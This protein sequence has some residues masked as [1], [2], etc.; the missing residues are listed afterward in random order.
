MMFLNLADFTVG[1]KEKKA[2][3]ELK[4][5]DCAKTGQPYEDEL[6]IWDRLYADRLFNEKYLTLG[7]LSFVFTDDL[8]TRSSHQMTNL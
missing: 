3:L 5:E 8:L 1:Q 7:A 6:Y 4:K 2:M